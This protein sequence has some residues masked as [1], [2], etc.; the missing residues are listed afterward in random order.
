MVAIRV[1]SLQITPVL[2]KK[3]RNKM[4]KGS[5]VLTKRVALLLGLV[6]PVVLGTGCGKQDYSEGDTSSATPAAAASPAAG[7][8]TPEQK[9][10]QLTPVPA[11]APDTS[12]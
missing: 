12:Q 7:K 9:T 6:V 2:S 10:G 1:Y 8:F 4:V 5:F 3:G 11:R